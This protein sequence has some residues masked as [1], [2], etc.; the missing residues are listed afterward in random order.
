[1][2]F[3]YRL[4]FRDEFKG[5]STKIISA[6]KFLLFRSNHIRKSKM[7]WLKKCRTRG[8]TNDTKGEPVAESEGNIVTPVTAS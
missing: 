4:N 8:S 6:N 7:I 3:S 5:I 2:I 1:V